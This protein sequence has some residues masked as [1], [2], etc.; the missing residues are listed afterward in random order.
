M[1]GTT[2]V[3]VLFTNNLNGGRV[4]VIKLLEAKHL[5]CSCCRHRRLQKDTP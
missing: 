5:N 2:G 1:V 3:V 4:D